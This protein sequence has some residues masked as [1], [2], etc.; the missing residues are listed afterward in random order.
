VGCLFLYCANANPLKGNPYRT[1][2]GASGRF[3]LHQ[4]NLANVLIDTG[5][6]Q[7]V[8]D[9]NR[10]RIFSSETQFEQSAQT[11]KGLGTDGMESFHFTIRQF[12]LGDLDLEK[13]EVMLLDLKHVNGSYQ[14]LGLP[15]IDMVIGGDLLQR[16]AAVIDYA[17]MQLVL[18]LP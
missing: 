7:T 1:F 10:M 18:T 4:C 14:Q 2:G 3:C 5:A 13:M 15:P 12:I 8:M 17:K 9:L 11:S 16:Y 6:S